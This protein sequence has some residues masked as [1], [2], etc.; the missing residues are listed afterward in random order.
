MKGSLAEISVANST[1][2]RITIELSYF[3]YANQSITATCYTAIH[4]PM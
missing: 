4:V 1:N 3:D 2:A